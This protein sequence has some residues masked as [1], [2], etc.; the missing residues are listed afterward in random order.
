MLLSNKKQGTL[1][2]T[3]KERYI[4]LNTIF[5]YTCICLLLNTMKSI[6][7]KKNDLRENI[8]KKN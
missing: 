6:G 2:D 4:N 7:L 5:L 8:I 3:G 1:R